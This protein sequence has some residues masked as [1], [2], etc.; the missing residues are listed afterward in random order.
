MAPPTGSSVSSVPCKIG[1]WSKWKFVLKPN[2]GTSGVVGLDLRS[3]SEVLHLLT[4]WDSGQPMRK[5]SS[6]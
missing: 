2:W 3:S 4:T 5:P 6:R 1:N